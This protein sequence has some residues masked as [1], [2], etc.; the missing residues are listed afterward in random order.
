MA[1]ASRKLRATHVDLAAA[2]VLDDLV[3]G[4]PCAAADD[5]G[6]GAGSIILAT[7]EIELAGVLSVGSLTAAWTYMEMASSQTSSNQT[8][9]MVQPPPRQ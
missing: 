1:A 9:S 6:L 5:G 4:M 7:R 3:R 8:F 2:V